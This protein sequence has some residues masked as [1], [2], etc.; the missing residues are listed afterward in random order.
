MAELPMGFTVYKAEDAGFRLSFQHPQSWRP[1]EETGTV[2]RYQQVRLL[3]PRN[4]EETFAAVLSVASFP[5]R[6]RGGDYEGLADFYRNYREHLPPTAQ[7]AKTDDRVV[8]GQKA[9]D[10]TYSFVAPRIPWHHDMPKE[11]FRVK[12]RALF[13]QNGAYLYRI[14]YST[15]LRDYD[16]NAGVLERVLESLQFFPEPGA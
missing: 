1:Q 15:D 12:T 7:V 14:T 6:D 11:E 2:E 5:T 9:Y 10:L 16:L 8:A 3:G 13:L 4:R